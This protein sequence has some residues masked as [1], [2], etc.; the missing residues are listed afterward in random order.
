MCFQQGSRSEGGPSC[1]NKLWSF[2]LTINY[3]CQIPLEVA[4]TIEGYE[5][6]SLRS[7]VVGILELSKSFASFKPR[8]ISRTLGKFRI[9]LDVDAE[10]FD[11]F[12]YWLD[13]HSIWG[14]IVFTW[15]FFAPNEIPECNST[16]EYL[17]WY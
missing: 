11:Y 15:F 12:S 13:G 1:S 6:R 16:D 4:S 2:N 8:H 7:F 3:F 10:F 14:D 5:D 17:M 9:N